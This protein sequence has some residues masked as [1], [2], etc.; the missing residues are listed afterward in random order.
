MSG[1][2]T[3]K[4]RIIVMILCT[5]FLTMFCIGGF[6]IYDFVQAEHEQIAAYR[7]DLERSVEER[8]KDET[9]MMISMMQS[10]Y[11]RQQSGELTEEQ[12][13]KAAADYLRQVRYGGGED[14]FSVDTFDGI[15]VVMPVAPALEG[16][17]R[18]GELDATGKPY[19]NILIENGKKE[20]GG[21]FDISFTKSPND[22]T[23]YPKRL[24]AKSFAPYR[25]VLCSGIFLDQIDQNV[26]ERQAIMEANL[27]HSIYKVI[28]V[29]VFLQLLFIVAAIYLGRKMGAPVQEITTQLSIMSE[30]D[31]RKLAQSRDTAE[32]LAREDDMGMMMRSLHQMHDHM[33]TLLQR[34]VD[35]A[36]YVAASAEELT[37]SA[38]QSREASQR[39]ADSV[40]AMANSCRDQGA[41]VETADHWS[42]K[43]M[44]HME[45]FS[46]EIAQS[47][48]EIKTTSAAAATGKANVD[49]AVQQ[50]DIIRHSVDESARVVTGLGEKS[51]QIGAIV[52]TI[53]EIASQTNLL[54]L[55]ASIEA[56][57]AGEQGRGFAVVAGEVGKLAEQSQR[58]AS[59]IAE[60]I[61]TIQQEAQNA[62]SAMQ[63]GVQQVANGTQAVDDAGQAFG[64]IFAGVSKIENRSQTMDGIVGE[65]VR[66]AREIQQAVGQ[67]NTMSHRV[68]AD[69]DVASSGTQEAAASTQEIAT[70]GRSLAEMSEKLQNAIVEFKI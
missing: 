6:F 3:M 58:A 36:Q 57:R 50:M 43:L 54:A 65:L 56:A 40:G 26:A 7:S 20:D 47:G 69:A 62:V 10:V 39:V 17:P 13:R 4:I 51:Q 12:A 25:W 64:E 19:L 24:Y 16:T 68:S 15:N 63:Q 53:A 37:S 1:F 9:N 29:I 35:T 46:V 61:G 8:L 23:P 48:K 55:N 21:F 32:M 30:G 5:S 67:I 45:T 59:E 49:H 60:L 41:Q 33:R 14:F 66:G 11:Q 52:D 44:E 22:P 18:T 31:F 34:L 42:T 27:R 70:A 2:K 28:G 38:D